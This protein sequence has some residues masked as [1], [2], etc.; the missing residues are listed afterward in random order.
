MFEIPLLE[1][2]A[3]TS[4]FFSY[5]AFLTYLTLDEDFV[6]SELWKKLFPDK[7]NVKKDYR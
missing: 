5:F 1:I 6:T 3:Q 4:N 7:L 2:A